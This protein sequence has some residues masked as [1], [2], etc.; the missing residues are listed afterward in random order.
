VVDFKYHVV[1]IVA[2]FLAL[3]IGIVLGT[4]VLS[5]DVLK[6]L[7]T[8]TSQLR[9]EAQ[10]LRAQNDGQQAQINADQ[11]FAEAL[12][13]MAVSGRLVSKKV[14]VIL[15]PNAQK[16][17]RDQAVQSLLDAG[18]TVSGE[19][20]I[21]GSYVDPQQA[22]SLDQLVTSLATG[23]APSSSSP[24]PQARAAALLASALVGAAPSAPISVNGDAALDA[25][26]AAGVAAT[27]TASFSASA[28]ARGSVSTKSASAT[29]S[30]GGTAST[31]P[32]PGG[33]ATSRPSLLPT[34]ADTVAPAPS[35]PTLLDV[36]S[37][38]IL[39]A[40]EK[41]GFVKI[42]QPPTAHATLALIIAPPPTAKPG[43]DSAASDKALLELVA[44]F[45]AAGG[46]T[47]MAGP[48]GS[49]GPGGLI[50]TL[51]GNGSISKV[52]TGVDDIDTAT[53]RIAA[54]F[55]LQ[56]Q[57]LGQVGQFGTGQ[58][59]QGPLPTPSPS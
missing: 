29:R 4:N 19:I 6:N 5:G 12:Q 40:L 10:D 34:P 31:S 52:V 48:L 16:S 55:A 53:G 59:A 20:D 47:V 26:G 1:S 2:V 32:N 44:A 7:K 58:G 56:W 30:A 39:A 37:T 8:Q 27:A 33:T 9:K 25:T 50:G 46:K 57:D 43:P 14:V 42:Q 15:L 23:Q 22:T 51:R 36:A 28:S 18:A 13:P 45:P 21:T 17:V 3:A 49:A 35:P 11:A 38:E 41:A 24:D 54:V